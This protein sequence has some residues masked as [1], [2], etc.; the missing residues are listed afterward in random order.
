MTTQTL[1]GMCSAADC[2][3][4]SS[5][6]I[7]T[8]AISSQ[9]LPDLELNESPEQKL[10]GASSLSC[11]NLSRRSSHPATDLPLLNLSALSEHVP[12]GDDLSTPRRN[13]ERIGR[14]LSRLKS[15]L[16]LG[17]KHTIRN[18]SL[19][20]ANNITHIINLGGHLYHNQ[21]RAVKYLSLSVRDDV[22][23]RIDDFFD[24][25]IDF[26]TDAKQSDGACV[27][28]CTQGI[29]RSGAIAVAYLMSMDN[30]TVEEALRKVRKNRPIIAPNSAF[31]NQLCEY[32][33][34]LKGGRASTWVG[35]VSYVGSVDKV[36]VARSIGEGEVDCIDDDVFII[37]KGEMMGIVVWKG[38]RARESVWKEAIR[39]ANRMANRV[40][41]D[42]ERRGLKAPFDAA[43]LCVGGRCAP[44]VEQTLRS[45]MQQRS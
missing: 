8:A 27:V 20:Q 13:V 28:A 16:Y 10:N 40:R 14:S 42:C 25:C 41:R 7:R 33:R 26:I 3:M 23:E 36:L 35:R 39:I 2:E 11:R 18:A 1:G 21:H 38:R 19:I 24:V 22:L 30:I 5:D 45:A 29:S 37:E 9:S 15:Y 44:Q 32:E 34:R 17:S 4:K 12:I 43:Q 31:L 6:A